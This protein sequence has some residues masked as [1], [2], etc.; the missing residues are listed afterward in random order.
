M[1]TVRKLLVTASGLA[2]LALPAFAHAQP[3]GWGSPFGG[4]QQP[5]GDYGYQYGRGF[6]GYPEFRDEEMHIRRE[7]NESVQDDMIEPD[8]ASDLY[9]QLNRVRA[10]EAHEFGVHGWNL[11]DDDRMAIRSDLDH[12]DRLVD[13][14]RDE[15]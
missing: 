11:P 3:Y 4:W 14:I 7:I 5:R 2:L 13:Q 6:P 1:S 15:P 9:G 12:L 8:D 10:R